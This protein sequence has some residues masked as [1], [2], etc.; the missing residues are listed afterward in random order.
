[1]H[2][3]GKTIKERYS[4]EPRL[5]QTSYAAKQYYIFTNSPIKRMVAMMEGIV[6][7]ISF[8]SQFSVWAEGTIIMCY[9][10]CCVKT[11]NEI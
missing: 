8:K 5:S 9:R 4:R 10:G 7:S 3:P 6:L 11:V 2:A 1:V